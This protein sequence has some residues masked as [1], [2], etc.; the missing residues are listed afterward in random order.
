MSN[1]WPGTLLL[2]Y[3]F[4]E[5]CERALPSHASPTP[6]LHDIAQYHTHISRPNNHREHAEG[7]QPFPGQLDLEPH[8]LT[9]D[10]ND[11]SGSSH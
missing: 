11:A 4:S 6:D 9:H 8:S 7:R 2:L 3:K 5:Q 1:L 10:H